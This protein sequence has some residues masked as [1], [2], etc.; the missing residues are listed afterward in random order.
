MCKLFRDGSL[1]SLRMTS[2]FVVAMGRRV[3]SNNCTDFYTKQRFL[4][5]ANK[6][7][8]CYYRKIKTP[9][10]CGGR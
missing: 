10:F 5:L 1:A 7:K 8:E 6:L 9:A 2:C 3:D 4:A